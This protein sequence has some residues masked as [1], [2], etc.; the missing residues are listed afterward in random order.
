MSCSIVIPVYN[1]AETIG[2]LVTRLVEVLDRDGL[3]IVLVNDGSPDHSGVVCR[4]LQERY[5]EHVVYVELAKN[6]GEHNAVMAGL[7]HTTG[8]HVVVMDDDFQN[9]PEEV[10]RLVAHAARHDYDVVYTRYERKHHHWFRNL[11][12]RFN[13]RVATV[14]LDKPPGLYLSSFKCMNRFTVNE[15]LRYTGPYPYIDGLIL[16]CTRRIGVLQVRHD[17]RTVGRSNYTLRKLLALWLNMFVNFSVLP[18]RVSTFAGFVASLLGVAL[19]VATTIEWILRPGT[20]VGWASIVVTLLTFSGV[21]LMMLGVVGEYIGR[22]FLSGNQTPQFVVREVLQEAEQ[23][24]IR[25]RGSINSET[26]ASSSREDWDFSAA[27]S[28]SVS[29]ISEPA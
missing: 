3:Q 9:P 16:R 12:S 6:F 28:R 23:P 5:P 8:S 26:E 27:T 29:S 10:R 4:T 18:L 11:G 17:P 1:G 2:P 7:R 14:L 20:P 22:L 24:C 15:V 19:G 25:I 21:Q 13:D